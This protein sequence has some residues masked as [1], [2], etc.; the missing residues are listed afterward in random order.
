MSTEQLPPQQK[1]A[2][3]SFIRSLASFKGDLATL[4][5]PPFLLSSQSIIEYSAYWNESPSLLVAPASEPNPEKRALLVLKW[6]IS[7]LKE[8]H[9]SKDEHGRRKRM[10]PLNPFLG[11]LFMGKWVDGAGTT[12]LVA[13]Q[14]SHHPPITAYNIWNDEHGVRLA[15]H[16]AP[17]ASFSTTVNIDRQGYSILHLDKFNEDYFITMPKIHIEGIMTGSLAPELSGTTYIR[18]SSGYT[19]EIH[20][21]SKG[22]LSGKRNTFLATLCHDD[23]ETEPLYMLEGQWSGEFT[24]KNMA[25]GKFVGKIDTSA[26]PRTRLTVAPI[27]KQ[28]PL[29]SRRAWQ[30]VVDGIE[31][32]DIL[33]IGQEKSKIENEQRELRKR[34]KAKGVEF[35]RRYFSKVKHDLVAEKLIKG[36]KGRGVRG[37]MDMAHGVWM[38]DE[39]KYRSV[40]EGRSDGVRGPRRTRFDSGVGGMLLDIAK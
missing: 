8:Q 21:S 4:T 32:G 27:E 1:G 10:K 18:S 29:E 31:K 12:N 17:K 13:E 6:F 19:A 20:Y 36:L 14:V 38:W 22:W 11:E 30:H 9:S 23:H 24:I 39:E 26:I 35:P 3:F 28:H 2:F 5:A 37:D 25:T 33:A 16:V 34:E 7:T 40:Q 15:G